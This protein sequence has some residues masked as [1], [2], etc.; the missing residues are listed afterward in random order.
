MGSGFT[1]GQLAKRGGVNVETVRYYERL[2]LL[3]PNTRK[4]SGYRVY[5][6]AELRRLH[7][8]KNAQALGFT[9]REIMEFLDLRV[10]SSSRCEDV[11]RKTQT[12]LAQVEKK[13]DDLQAL[14]RSLR[15]LIR[16]CEAKRLTDHCPILESLEDPVEESSK[17]GEHH[18]PEPMKRKEDPT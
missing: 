18:K 7:F 5:G 15:D 14:A 16:S 12:K 10:S 4:P 11:K 17:E 1:I 8:I 9:L 13:I 6:R 3:S 2:H